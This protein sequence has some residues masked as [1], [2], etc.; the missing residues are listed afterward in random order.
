VFNG[1]QL[2]FIYLIGVL[3]LLLIAAL[4]PTLNRRTNWLLPW[5][6]LGMFAFCRGMH[7]L[8]NLPT[9]NQLI[10]GH[11]E[12][13]KLVLLFLSL[14]FLLEFGRAGSNLPNG[15]VPRPWVYIP[16][17]AL[18]LVGRMLGLPGLIGMVSFGLSAAGGAWAAWAL[19]QASPKFPKGKETLITA[20]IIMFLYGIASCFPDSSESSF[21]MAGVSIHLVRSL[22]AI[23]L[24]ACIFRCGQVAMDSMM[25]LH[26]QKIHQYFAHG[27]TIGLVCIA[28][29]GL[30][31]S[32]GI[33]YLANKAVREAS[34]KSQSTI[35]R[36]QE[37]IN[38]EMEKADRL[39]QLLAGS[40]P[41]ISALA[42]RQ[43]QPQPQPQVR[44]YGERYGERERNIERERSSEGQ[45]VR[46]NELLDRFSQMEE[47]FGIC[48]IMDLAGLTI[49]SSNRNQSDSFV[50]KNYSFRPYFKQAALGLQGRYFALGVTSKD[51]GYYT[52]APIRNEQGGIIGV[53]VIKRLIRTASELKHA[54]DPGYI[55]FLVD[56]HGIVALSNQPK[57][58]LSALWPVNEETKKELVT[59]GQF[60]NGPF[61]PI[62]D[63]KPVDGK[64]YQLE[65]QLMMALTQPILMEG[66]AMVNFGST[67]AIP[68]YKLL[69][70]LAILVL[71]LALIGFYVSWDL[72]SSKAADITASDWSQT[73]DSTSYGQIEEQ[74]H[75]GELRY[76]ELMQS[77]SLVSEMGDLLQGCNSSRDAVPVITKYM[78]RLFP[79]LS[80]AIYLSTVRDTLEVM[81]VWGEFPPEEQ[82]FDP[83]DCWALR[84]GR[85]YLVEDANASLPCPHVSKNL[86]AGYQCWPLSAQGKTLGILHLRQSRLPSNPNA[87]SE[88]RKETNR[89]LISSVV[90]QFTMTLVNLKLRETSQAKGILNSIVR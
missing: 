71:G 22:L 73:A 80:G 49:A 34:T 29:V 82:R 81:G 64:D 44:R 35:Q 1:T 20:G 50:G 87:N 37:V 85:Q 62:L 59:S 65:G 77:I 13:V 8:L 23:G 18:I 52:S 58:V 42:G 89:Q 27:T 88:Q 61:A 32:L 14:I 67:Q 33:N 51:L 9:L 12:A 74:L 69:G 24:A 84:R 45:I 55:S 30:V 47:G 56:P 48:Y 19:F 7:D 83:D 5:K 76:R 17:A 70:A 43:P 72:T 68:F 46:V 10:P 60:G 31:G 79:G 57:Y 25:E 63:Q 40:S 21:A 3:A 38:N 26:A 16:L 86:P 11:L 66:W 54:I 4:T 28:V 39:V 53:A 6:W 75:Q 2:D 36:L 15:P 78:Q 90:D 41:I